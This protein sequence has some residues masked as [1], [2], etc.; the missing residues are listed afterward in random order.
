MTNLLFTVAAINPVSSAYGGVKQSDM[1][2]LTR[3]KHFM[4]KPSRTEHLKYLNREYD[5]EMEDAKDAGD[6]EWMQEVAGRKALA[7]ALLSDRRFEYTPLSKEE[8]YSDDSNFRATSYRSLKQALDDSDGTKDSLL[9]VWND[10][11]DYTQKKT[12]EDILKNFVDVN[13]KANDALKGGTKSSV[14][15]KSKSNYEKILDIIS[16][17]S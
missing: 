8:Q 16:G 7:N 6:E 5:K 1:A 13:D 2:E 3:F 15:T 9:K 17:N 11:C 12:I 4:V 10:F 14:F